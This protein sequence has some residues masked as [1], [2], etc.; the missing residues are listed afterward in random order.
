[1]F[2]DLWLNGVRVQN[3]KLRITGAQ[4]DGFK[5]KGFRCRVYCTVQG[6]GLTMKYERLGLRIRGRASRFRVRD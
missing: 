1:M 6:S 5:A 3:V 2:L 4:D